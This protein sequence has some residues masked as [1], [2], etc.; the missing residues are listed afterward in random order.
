LSLNINFEV[1][2]DNE[3]IFL[4]GKS[5][6]FDKDGD[7]LGVIL[8]FHE[9]IDLNSFFKIGGDI[10]NGNFVLNLDGNSP[11]FKSDDPLL[12]FFV[13]QLLVFQLD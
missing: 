7:L 10:G 12:F 9:N 5:P 6:L 13:H 8:F 1:V 2:D 4:E 11:L 3:G